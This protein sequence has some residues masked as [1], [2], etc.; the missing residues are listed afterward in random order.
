MKQGQHFGSAVANVFMWLFDRMFFGLPTF[1]RIGCC[2]VRPSFVFHPNLRSHFFS[3]PVRFFDQ[4]FLGVVCGS[5]IVTSPRFRFRATSPVLHQLRDFCHRYPAS[6]KITQI[7]SVLISGNPSTA[8]LNA[9]CSVTND[10]VLLPSFSGSGWWRTSAKVRSHSPALYFAFGVPP[11]C[12]WIARI[13][14]R[15]NRP[16]YWDTASPD[17][18]PAFCAAS[19]KVLPAATAR[20]S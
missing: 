17:F 16:T 1:S 7:R 5:V 14:S 4:F 9:F 20:I 6:C 10:Q 18:L 3:Q 2:L 11:G 12:P 15:L 8:F 19:V 13:P